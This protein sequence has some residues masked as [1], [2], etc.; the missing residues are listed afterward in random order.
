MRYQPLFTLRVRHP[1]YGGPGTGGRIA[2]RLAADATTRRRLAGRRC[3]ARSIPGGVVVS[4]ELDAAGAPRVPANGA[5]FRF[6][7]EPVDQDF[8]QVTDLSDLAVLEAEGQAALY[9]NRDL[10]AATEPRALEL[11]GQPHRRL[12]SGILAEVEVEIPAGDTVPAPADWTVELRASRLPWIY[13]CLT[14][15]AADRDTL[16]L[17]DAVPPNGEEPLL[18]ERRE[19][20]DPGDPIARQL[21]AG[22]APLRLLSFVSTLD[23]V[24]R[25]RPRRHLELRQ[26]GVRRRGPLPNPSPRRLT[27]LRRSSEPRPRPALYQ[28][29]RILTP[30]TME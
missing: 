10:A 23:V 22:C 24:C 2:A 16:E 21:A 18:F 14:D 7:L 15:L 19:L 12:P 3:V 9:T 6:R 25:P 17:V 11:I 5:A 29:V 28:I 13:Y 26:G 4:R 8:T 1:Y 30:Q 27:R 20:D